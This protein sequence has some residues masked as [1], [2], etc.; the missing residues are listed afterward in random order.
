LPTEGMDVFVGQ[1]IMTVQH[2]NLILPETTDP[3]DLPYIEITLNM[4]ELDYITKTDITRLTRAGF[5]LE[6]F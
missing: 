3:D 2:I 1:T 5:A 6:T 4:Q